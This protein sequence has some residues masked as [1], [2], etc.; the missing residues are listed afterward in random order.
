MGKP[1]DVYPAIWQQNGTCILLGRITAADGTGAATGG[2]GEGNWIKQADIS[3]ITCKVFD[4]S[5]SGSTPTTVSITTAAILDTPVT[6]SVLWTQDAVGYNFE[7][8]LPATAFPSAHSYQVEVKITTTG[9]AV[10]YGK[11]EGSAAESLS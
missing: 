8:T 7:F 2:A 4:R 3:A 10:A 6:S 11:W 5:V 1:T 9:G